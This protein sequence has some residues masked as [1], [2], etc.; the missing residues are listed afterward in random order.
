[1]RQ[2][3]G[4]SAALALGAVTYATPASAEHLRLGAAAPASQTVE[5]EVYM[6]LHN[7]AGLEALLAA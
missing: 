1:M 4:L 7:K 6:P 5:F 2:M 3:I